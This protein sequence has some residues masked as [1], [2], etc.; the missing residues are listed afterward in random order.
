MPKATNDGLHM[1]LLPERVGMTN[2]PEQ[3]VDT[4]ECVE[5]VRALVEAFAEGGQTLERRL[6]DQYAPE[7][8]LLPWRIDVSAEL[9]ERGMKALGLPTP[10]APKPK[11]IPALPSEAQAKALAALAGEG[12]HLTAR[13]SRFSSFDRLH[14][15]APTGTESYAPANFV[16]ERA[17]RPGGSHAAAT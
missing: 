13:E 12:A 7:S 9:V 2:E 17:G 5:I 11:K 10:E 4:A 16:A 8:Y 1:Q 3:A 14:Y 6:H 15:V